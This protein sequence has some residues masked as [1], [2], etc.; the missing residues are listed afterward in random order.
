MNVGVA[1]AGYTVVNVW[2]PTTLGYKEGAVLAREKTGYV[3]TAVKHADEESKKVLSSA[4]I[5]RRRSSA[6]DPA[7][8]IYV[9]PNNTESAAVTQQSPNVARAHSSD[10]W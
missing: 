2:L 1:A 9:P 3:P 7:G 10:V 8:F 4:R 5:I 6:E